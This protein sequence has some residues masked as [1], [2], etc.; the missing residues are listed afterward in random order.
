MKVKKKD[1][2]SEK[3]LGKKRFKSAENSVEKFR[4]YKRGK[5]QKNK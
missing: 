2:K 1:M 4:N 5:I 3:N